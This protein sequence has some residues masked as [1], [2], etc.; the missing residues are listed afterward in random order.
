M[1]FRTLMSAAALL[2]LTACMHTASEQAA[3]APAFN[4]AACTERDFVIYFD[5]GSFEITQEARRIIDL[6]ARDIAGCTVERVR[7]LGLSASEEQGGGSAR[8]LSE[9]RAENLADY[10]HEHQRWP[11]SRFE[12]LAG[13]AYGATTSEGLDVPVRNRARIVVTARAP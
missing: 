10:L 11:R 3:P 6:Q 5:E 2:T 1:M 7:V 8:R 4:P 9:D 12:V 13:G